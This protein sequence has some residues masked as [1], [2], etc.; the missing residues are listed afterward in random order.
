[1][2]RLHSR[3]YLHFLGVLLVVAV[4]TAVV[5]ALGARDAFRREMA[6]R[7]TRHLV[8]LVGERIGDPAALTARLQQ[9]HDDLHLAV[10]VRSLDGR[11]IA[12]AG[13]DLP[14]LTPAEQ[15][16]VRAGR[17][18]VRP[19]P[20]GF[21]AAPIL[22]PSTGAVV[23]IVEGA[24]PRPMG[25]P[26]LWR[27]VLLVAV[28][29]LA[30]AVA[31]RPLAQRISR[32]VE[33]LTAA[34]RRLGAGDL[35]ARVG[36]QDAHA[37]RRT[38]EITELTRAFNEMAER[39]ERLVR[40]EK[41]LL[42]NVSH[43]LRSPLARIRVALALLPREADDDRR[44]RDIERD[45]AELDRLVEDVLTTARLE[46]TGLPTHLAAVETRALL[47]NL[48]ERAHHDPLTAA[49]PVHVEDG[50]PITVTADEALLRRALWNLV[51]NA[52]KYGEPPIALS[53]I[54]EGERVLLRVQDEGAGVA[55]ADRERVFAPFYRGDAARTPDP[56]GDARRGV[57][58]GLTLARRVAEVHG[59]DIAIGPTSEADGQARGCRVT[60]SIPL[61]AVTSSA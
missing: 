61:T 13:D 18:V 38:D 34:A 40:A 37:R 14:S 42:A 12:S 53:A 15:A 31:T 27:P 54:V 10:R 41:E 60:L 26:P 52:A 2:A 43:E 30:V 35:S 28:A 3:I 1:V 33:R 23:A 32:P 48:V 39:V 17:V 8:S 7:V 58:L 24:V 55:S 25:T 51:E 47:A 44:L 57:G 59:G 11:V 20:M 19:R 45:L 49:L 4:T 21:A 29:L 9:I 5:F 50:P 56:H 6:P 16:D 46:A 22:D 36:A